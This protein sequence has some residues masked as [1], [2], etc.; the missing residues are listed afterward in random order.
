[1]LTAATWDTAT[2]PST[3]T[4][5]ETTVMFRMVP[6]VDTKAM[7]CVWASQTPR[8][9]DMALWLVALAVAPLPEPGFATQTGK[10]VTPERPDAVVVGVTP[11]IKAVTVIVWVGASHTPK[12]VDIALWLVADAVAPLPEPGLA[13]QTGRPVTPDRPEA[14][15]VPEIV[16]S[17]TVPDTTAETD[18]PGTTLTTWVPRMV[19]MVLTAPSVCVWTKITGIPVVRLD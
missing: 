11:L 1:M 5:V 8:A 16:A 6:T 2:V 4:T 15:V 17:E 18:K 7:V 13:T 12:A 9:V 3:V 14:V 10:A 19:M